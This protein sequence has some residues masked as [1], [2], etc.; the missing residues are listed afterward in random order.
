MQISIESPKTRGLVGVACTDSAG[1]GTDVSVRHTLTA[2]SETG[3]T[4]VSNFPETGHYFK[5]IDEWRTATAD[6]LARLPANQSGN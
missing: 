1:G 4:F 3:H 2:P 6:A 5:M